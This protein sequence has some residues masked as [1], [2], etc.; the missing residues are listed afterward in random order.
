MKIKIVSR[1]ILV[2]LMISSGVPVLNANLSKQ[3]PEGT[4]PVLRR[5]LKQ[6]ENSSYDVQKL[7]ISLANAQLNN[8]IALART[9][10]GLNFSTGV[11]ARWSSFEDDNGDREGVKVGLNNLNLSTGYL[12]YDFGA[13][14]ALKR[15]ANRGFELFEINYKLQMSSIARNIRIKF[16][17]LVIAKF[18]LE[19]LELEI[20]VNQANI[21]E[22]TRKFEQGRMSAE[23]YERSM[24]SRKLRTLELENRRRAI[25]RQLQDFNELIGVDAMSY[26]EVPSTIP[27]LE[28]VNEE[29]IAMAR[30]TKSIQFSDL[31]SIQQ[32]QLDLENADDRII[33]TQS[34]TRPRLSVGGGVSLV[35]EPTAQNQ[36]VWTANAGLSMNWNIYSGGRN[37]RQIIK[38]YNDRLNRMAEYRRTLNRTEMDLD[39]SVEDLIYRYNRLEVSESDYQM[40]LQ[41]YEKSKDEYDRGRISELHFM[42]VELR[43]LYQER[44]IYEVRKAYMLSI[45]DF[46]STLGKDPVLDILTPPGEKDI[47]KYLEKN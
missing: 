47:S 34:I 46:L 26:E 18:S 23:T 20:Q 37:K 14:Q 42:N 33:D 35:I 39:R 21:D 31:P 17:D 24:N 28:N 11:G 16:L 3:T 30:R 25:S 36:G 7:D 41:S 44:N 19:T 6:A 4:Y 29:L 5:V 40:E 32:M 2:A 43:R 9:R 38:T 22:D 8:E 12:L 45:A 13:K 10:P 15:M 1:Y 27:K